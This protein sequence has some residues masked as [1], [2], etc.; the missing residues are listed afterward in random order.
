M[1]RGLSEFLNETLRVLDTMIQIFK[2]PLRVIKN[3]L[4]KLIFGFEEKDLWNLDFCILA[5]VLPRLRAFKKMP[6]MG[7]P[8]EIKSP[9]QFEAILDDMIY[10]LEVFVKGNAHYPFPND[11]EHKRF[12]KGRRMYHKYFHALWD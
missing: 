1:G 6:R 12:E 2:K 3:K 5:F 10:Y 9:E 11:P 7:Y 4:H 8:A